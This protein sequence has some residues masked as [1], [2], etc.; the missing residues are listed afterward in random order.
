MIFTGM[1]GMKGI[2]VAYTRSPSSPP[3]LFEH[4]SAQIRQIRPIRVQKKFQP[5]TIAISF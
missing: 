1:K 4:P 2:M 5:T 3:S